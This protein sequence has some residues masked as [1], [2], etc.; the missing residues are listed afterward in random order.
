MKRSFITSLLL[1]GLYINSGFGQTWI[2]NYNVPV[3]QYG[4]TL[5]YPF[6]GGLNN[7]QFS[8]ADI[9]QDGK[10]DIFIFDRTGNKVLIFLNEGSTGEINYRYWHQ[11]E[12]VFPPLKDWAVL[13]DYNCDG[14]PDLITGFDVGIQTWVASTDGTKMIFTE[15]VHKIQYNEVGFDFDLSVGNIDIPGFA[16]VNYD[17]DI[18]VLTFRMSSGG[19]VEYYENRAV[20]NGLPCG[21]WD[22]DHVSSCWGNF[23][24][25]G[26][27]YS[28]EL[29]YDCKGVNKMDDGLHAGS[30]FMLFD[31]DNDNDLDLVLGDLAFG[32]LNKLVNGGDNSFAH[33][34]DQDTT[35]PAYNFPYNVP[36]FPAPFLVDINND[37]IKDMVVAPNNINLSANTKNVYYY[38]NSATDGTYHFEYQTDSFL[39]GDMID[40]GE[41]AFPVFFD[42]NYDGLMDLVIGNYG[43]FKDGDYTGALA[44]YENTGTTTAPA[45]TLISSDFG[46][47]SAFGFNSIV[48]TFGD[49]DD[50]GDDDMLIG[51][52]EGFIHYFKNIG[53]PGGPAQFILFGAEYQGIDPGHNS[54]PQLI[55]IDGDGL[56]DLICGEQN[57]NLNYYH[58]TGTAAA[59]IFT[60]EN[61]FWGNVDVRTV[62]SITGS[63]VP[64]LT[65]N[66]SGDFVLYVGCEEGT[67]FQYDPTDDFT[68]AFTKITNLFNNID[69]GSFSS[70]NATDL[71]GDGLSDIITGNARGGITL[72]RDE[73]ADYIH[74]Q[75]PAGNLLMYPDPASDHIFVESNFLPEGG[76]ILVFNAEG[77]ICRQY[78]ITNGQVKMQ[79][80]ISS[81]I[82]GIYL[83]KI[84]DAQFN[85]VYYGK[86]IKL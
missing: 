17:G 81:F 9:N 2:Y 65:K 32:N 68:G 71:D 64:F 69:E 1:I 55:D 84:T 62:G 51:E 13:V 7:P 42:Y 39:V 5:Q 31:E 57:G 30:T 47:L 24:E 14:L 48:P 10:D 18:D 37:E 35:F 54:A 19:T 56:Q 29:D 26:I 60:L 43:Y 78:P 73:N 67:I 80:D 50:D 36:I 85:P 74:P 12:T 27:T 33:I 83:I 72:Y 59:P 22:L 86:F 76:K 82:K 63:S 6:A 45:F 70:I 11:Y 40:L 8:K 3:T 49:M 75:N 44:L 20:E 28:V 52:Y 66:A 58:N 15:D 25:S 38:K 79:L 16:D 4:H 77:K 46:G 21:T 34:T 61:E 41:G 23:Y 53:P